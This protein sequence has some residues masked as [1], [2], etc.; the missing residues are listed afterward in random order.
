MSQNDKIKS[1]FTSIDITALIQELKQRL[2]GMRVTN[3]YDVNQKTY[4]FKFTRSEKKEILIIENGVRFHITKQE[5]Q[6]NKI[7]SGFTMKFRK[8]LRSK[9]IEDIK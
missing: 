4:L 3:I 2:I 5:I 1:R 8:Y 7:P 9:R 6:K